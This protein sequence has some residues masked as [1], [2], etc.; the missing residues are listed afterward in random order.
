MRN[1]KN[2]RI[3]GLCD[4]KYL[5]WSVAK[6]KK[7]QCQKTQYRLFFVCRF[8]QHQCG[9]LDLSWNLVS[10]S[11]VAILKWLGTCHGYLSHLLC[12]LHSASW[13]TECVQVDEC[14]GKGT[15]PSGHS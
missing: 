15:E 4:S 12:A 2:D 10:A 5:Q 6:V 7:F 11:E 14:Y 8:R 3:I 13:R 9:V 1:K